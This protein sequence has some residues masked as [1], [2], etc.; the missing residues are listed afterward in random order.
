MPLTSPSTA[1]C[2]PVLWRVMQ[3]TSSS[4]LPWCT[5]CRETTFSISQSKGSKFAHQVLSA[6]AVSSCFSSAWIRE[7]FSPAPGSALAKTSLLFSAS[8]GHISSADPMVYSY[9]SQTAFGKS[10][11]PSQCQLTA[12]TI[13]FA[14]EPADQ[15]PLGGILESCG[16]P[17]VKAARVA[18]NLLSCAC[19]SQRLLIKSDPLSLLLTERNAQTP[20][21]TERF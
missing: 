14:K 1:G 8:S 16:L 18:A 12:G 20:H 17:S 2:G 3:R 7:V 10:C 4:C 11:P 5:G 9:I 19:L 21:W 15:W 13:N 6:G